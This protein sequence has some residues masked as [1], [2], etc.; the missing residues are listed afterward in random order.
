MLKINE[1][2]IVE[3]R[4][5]RCKLAQIVDADIVETS[6]FAVFN[7]SQLRHYILSLAENKGIIILTDSD[8]AGFQ[9]R[10]YIKSFVPERYIRNAYIPD[11]IG[12][13]RRKRKASRE[14]KLGV[15]GVPDEVI[16]N[17]LLSSGA[18]ESVKNDNDRDI[19]NKASFYS[20]GLSGG[21]NSAAKRRM[22]TEMLNLPERI[23]ANDLI[24]Y[25]NAT[26]SKEKFLALCDESGVLPEAV[27]G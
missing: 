25:I 11:I 13:E 4:Y 10:N 23:S 24:A 18:T 14:N 22:I 5:D 7:D 17:A 12:K 27:K 6:G 19:L 9:I 2:I 15:E 20:L 16:I 1:V 8:A 26:M 3:G 21:K